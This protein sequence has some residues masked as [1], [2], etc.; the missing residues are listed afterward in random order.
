[1]HACRHSTSQA[2]RAL[3]P[4]SIYYSILPRIV[5]ELISTTVYCP[6]SFMN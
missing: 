3:W 2:Y 1:M 6:E 4:A 5:H